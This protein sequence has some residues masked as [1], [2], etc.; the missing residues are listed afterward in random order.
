MIGLSGILLFSIS[1]EAVEA[2]VTEVSPQEVYISPLSIPALV[3]SCNCVQFALSMGIN[4]NP[5]DEPIVGGSLK[6]WEGPIGHRAF[7]LAIEED[8]LIIVESNFIPCQ[9]TFRR[10][11]LDS[12]IIRGYTD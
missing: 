9:I 7:I 11:P 5:I 8:S 12:R 4:N 2:P 1:S 6:T 3:P 10:I